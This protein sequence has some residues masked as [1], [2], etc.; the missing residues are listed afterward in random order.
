MGFFSGISN[1]FYEVSYK[2]SI[3]SEQKLRKLASDRRANPRQRKICL[4]KADLI[5]IG[6]DIAEVGR[7]KRQFTQNARIKLAQIPQSDQEKREEIK[8]R[9]TNDWKGLNAQS[10]S[11][12]EQQ[13]KLREELNRY[14]N[15]SEYFDE[16]E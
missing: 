2:F 10:N 3:H 14:I 7:Q 1:L 15:D 13:R 11:L 12:H 9:F 8:R 6:R 5:A 4:M 16:E